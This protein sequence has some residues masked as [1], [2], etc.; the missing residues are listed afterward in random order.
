MG[1]SIVIIEAQS[2]HLKDLS[3]LAKKYFAESP[4]SST[5]QFDSD[6]TLESLRRG[7]ILASHRVL[8]VEY[9]SETV[10]GAFAY[11]APY[12]WCPDIRVNCEFIYVLPEHRDK[13]F[14]EDLLLNL[15]NWAEAMNAKEICAGDI[16]FRPPVTQR[17]LEN[18][19][20]QDPGV[21]LRQVLV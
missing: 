15:K 10:G 12:T 9:N 5:H 14:A 21:M 19:G 11:A 17:W 2:Y 20:Y 4:Y 8:A 1:Q 16:G 7:M 3:D 6:T 18:Q 13:G